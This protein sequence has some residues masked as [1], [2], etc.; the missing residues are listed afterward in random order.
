MLYD[1]EFLFIK[2]LQILI[3]FL[4]QL[5]ETIHHISSKN[6]NQIK[7]LHV[8]VSIIFKLY[9][10]FYDIVYPVDCCRILNSMFNTWILKRIQK[11][12]IIVKLKIYYVDKIIK[13]GYF[14]IFSYKIIFKLVEYQTMMIHLII[15]YFK[16]S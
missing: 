1:L 9:L 5:N 12:L 15:H 11:Y 6:Y 10:I 16:K 3:N 7:N 2:N 14:F 8:R 13:I 4:S